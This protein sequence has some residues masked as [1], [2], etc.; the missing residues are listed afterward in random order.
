MNEI[1]TNKALTWLASRC[2]RSSA[3]KL[4]SL[5]LISL[6]LLVGCATDTE[7]KKQTKYEVNP[8]MGTLIIYARQNTPIQKYIGSIYVVVDGKK[9]GKLKYGEKA[10]IQLTPGFRKVAIYAYEIYSFIPGMK[11]DWDKFLEIEKNK[12]LVYAFSSRPSSLNCEYS[13]A[14]GVP[15]NISYSCPPF[16]TWAANVSDEIE[17]DL[18]LAF[19]FSE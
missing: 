8:E 5:I 17:P 19:D 6:T 16:A 12:K 3:V 11:P 4:P 9:I 18:N 10:R 15:G 2:N 14:P 7:V 13:Y 1:Y